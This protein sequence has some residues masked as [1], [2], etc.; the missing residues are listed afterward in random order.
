MAATDDKPTPKSKS[1]G[2]TDAEKVIRFMLGLVHPLKAEM[3]AV[4]EII[5]AV[6]PEISERIKWNAPS[7]HYH[8]VDLVTFNPRLSGKVHLVFHHIAIVQ[9]KSDLLEGTYKDRRMMY[10][11][12]MAAVAANKKELE[13]IMNE[14][15]QAVAG[16]D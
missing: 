12:D 2:L 11:K 7:Y 1:G 14:Y 8:G 5:N 15:V 6:N 3:E 16:K 13:R 10:F 4:R 9:V